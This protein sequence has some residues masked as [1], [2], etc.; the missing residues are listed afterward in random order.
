MPRLVRALP[1]SVS[2]LYQN[3]VLTLDVMET[4]SE[5]SSLA[6]AQCIHRRYPY[7]VCTGQS[8]AAKVLR[9]KHM[10]VSF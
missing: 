4:A 7:T 2:G 1:M 3:V 6:H 9:V 10:N 5:A 8:V